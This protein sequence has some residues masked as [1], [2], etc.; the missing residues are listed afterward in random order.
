VT[1]V[2][3]EDLWGRHFES[4]STGAH[5]VVRCGALRVE[6]YRVVDGQEIFVCY[7]GHGGAA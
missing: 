3:R 7:L 6:L 4:Y 5:T 1:V 2:I